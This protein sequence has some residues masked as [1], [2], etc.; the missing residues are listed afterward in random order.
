MHLPYLILIGMIFY[1]FYFKKL[2]VLLR[3]LLIPAPYLKSHIIYFVLLCITS[4]NIYYSNAYPYL[5]SSDIYH[6]LTERDHLSTTFFYSLSYITEHTF[7][8]T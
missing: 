5:L 2:S 3:T 6:L 4:L 7:S 1:I 8:I